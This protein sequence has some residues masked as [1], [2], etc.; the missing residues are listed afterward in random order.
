[1][2]AMVV[3]GGGDSLTFINAPLS[4]HEAVAEVVAVTEAES[5]SVPLSDKDAVSDSQ[6][7]PPSPPSPPSIS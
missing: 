5:A 7:P 4:R 6:L 1:M 2:V 3:V